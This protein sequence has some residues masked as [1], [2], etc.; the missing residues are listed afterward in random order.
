ME[1]SGH[2]LISN[3]IPAFAKMDWEKPQK[4]K[5][6]SGEQVSIWDMNQGSSDHEA[7]VLTSWL[8][9][10]AAK[11]LWYSKVANIEQFCMKI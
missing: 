5:T 1:G 7:V 2:C 3:T 9:R 6:K 4:K 10:F 11:Q 8:Q